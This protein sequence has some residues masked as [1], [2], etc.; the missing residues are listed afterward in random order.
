MAGR[1]GW[2]RGGALGL[3]LV[4]GV[5]GGCGQPVNEDA[6]APEAQAAP[7][8]TPIG[9][10]IAL[11]Q[12][13]LMGTALAN[14]IHAWMDIPYA[15]PPVG[16]LRWA[17]PAPAEPWEG[18]RDAT[19][20]GE[21]CVQPQLTVEPFVDEPRPQSEDCLTLN[22]WSGAGRSD[23]RRPVM[24]WIHGG[25][26]IYG[27]GDTDGAPLAEQGVVLVSINYRL[28]PLGFFAHPELSAASP[29][30][31]SG[32]QGFLDQIAALRWVR[33]NVEAFGG[34]PNRVTIFG[35]SAG[36]LSVSTLMASPLAAGL[37]HRAI[38]QSGSIFANRHGLTADSDGDGDGGGEALGVQL[39]EALGAPS[40]NAVA[41]LRERDAMEVLATWDEGTT[42]NDYYRQPVIDGWLLPAAAREIFAAG[43]HNDVPLMV[44]SNADEGSAIHPVVAPN[45]AASTA[46]YAAWLEERLGSDL[47]ERALE[48]YPAA[49]DEEA[50]QA[51]S[52]V[53][54]DDM[55][56][57]AMRVWANAAGEAPVYLYYFSRVP[58]GEFGEKYGSYHAAEI[59]YV[60]AQMDAA[61]TS[62]EDAQLATAMSAAWVRFAA[63]GDPNGG[64]LPAWPAY[65][66]EREDY[67]EFGDRVG[68]GTALR[69]EKVALWETHYAAGGAPMAA[70]GTSSASAAEEPMSTEG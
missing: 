38:G 27:S 12:G 56:T 14:G 70:A 65:T 68:P 35:E 40:E 48:L 1:R 26:L 6:P 5:L 16:E 7:M 60:F 36:S 28:G 42:F 10:E 41:A 52:D 53:V 50:A 20:F 46:A 66:A 30:G 44:G 29:H 43:Q 58:P 57:W 67:M 17:A 54:C 55:F 2:R 33:D 15:A 22:V 32:N 3:G 63:T 51:L 34:D 31:V 64:D 59:P 25:A 49:T 21:N 8:A 19:A 9:P 18:V 13:R 69:S 47:A 61:T 62:A 24:V 11:T 37:F 4:L 45:A 39:A 23:E